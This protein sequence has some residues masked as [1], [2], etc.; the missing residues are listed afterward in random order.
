MFPN[1][2]HAA[3]HRRA[4]A[5]DVATE[6]RMARHDIANVLSVL[7]KYGR[8]WLYRSSYGQHWIAKLDMFVQGEGVSYQVS[9]N[10]EANIT[11]QMAID[12]L[13]RLVEAQPSVGKVF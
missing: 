8:P 1:I 3:G 4:E 9:A 11:P 13:V 5:K 10:D 6:G 2:M 7:S 12:H